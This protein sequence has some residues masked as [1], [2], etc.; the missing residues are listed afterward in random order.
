LFT[1]IGISQAIIQSSHG[2]ERTFLD[3]AW[4]IQVLRGFVI[5]GLGIVAAIFL[6]V[7]ARFDW[8]AHD[9]VYAFP[10]LPIII[11]VACFSAV[12]M[13]FQTTKVIVANR[14]LDIM[15]VTLI[16]LLSQLLAL[17]FTVGVGLLTRSIWSYI[18]AGLLASLLS[19]LFS[20]IFLR[21]AANRFAWDMSAR[22]ELARFGRWVFFSS[23]LGGVAGNSDRMLL[24]GIVVPAVLG[25]YSIASN[26]VAVVDGVAGRIFGI[27][28]LPALANIHRSQPERF[29]LLFFRIK[30]LVDGCLVGLSG[31]LFCTSHLIVASLYDARYLQAGAIFQILSLGLLLAR[32]NL[33]QSAYLALGLPNYLTFLNV[34]KL[35]SICTLLPMLFYLDGQQGTIFAIAFHMVPVVVLTFYLNSFHRLNNVKLE[36][37]VLG[38]WPIGWL[39]GNVALKAAAVAKGMLDG[40]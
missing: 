27:V 29:N 2:Q 11:I 28:A 16:D 7:A 9:S 15:R 17:A 40:F 5:W 35:V 24:A 1:D 4:T 20:E 14:N 6:L 31:F 12:I 32:Y 39:M 10:E 23:A 19:V 38:F 36:F 8:V 18:A 26:L 3:T 13:G 25:F 30:L 33:A 37:V 22:V 34:T 21:G